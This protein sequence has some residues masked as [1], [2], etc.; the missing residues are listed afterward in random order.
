MNMI[1]KWKQYFNFEDILKYHRLNTDNKMLA[2]V[3]EKPHLFGLAKEDLEGKIEQQ[4]IE[5]II[6]EYFAR[7]S[8]YAGV[9]ASDFLFRSQWGHNSPEWFDHRHHLL[10]PG[11]YFTDL[12]TASADNVLKVLPLHGKLLDLCAGDGFYDYYFYRK[13]AQEITCVELNQE[14]YQHAIRLHKAANITYHLADVLNFG[15]EESYYDVVLIRGA[16]EHF[17]QENQQIIFR[18][19]LS[20]LKPGGW[21]VGD[22]P[23][24]QS[25]EKLLP[26]HEHEWSGELEM[27]KDLEKVFDEIETYSMESTDCV[28]L[29]WKCKKT[30]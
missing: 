25:E 2:Q 12:W 21:F 1:G 17:S 9:I 26:A 30:G 13:R 24:N 27:R 23:A 5:L 3:F 10:N 7:L 14:A 19:A 8:A 18:K 6:G 15:L 11:K 22:T 4:K 20:A 28:M 29:F 16:I